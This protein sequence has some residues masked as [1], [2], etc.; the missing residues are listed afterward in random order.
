VAFDDRQER[1]TSTMTHFQSL[2]PR[3]K[4]SKLSY[5]YI[6]LIGCVILLSYGLFF[7]IQY[8]IEDDT[9]S[10]LVDEQIHNQVE[11]TK[12]ISQHISSDL[13]AIVL[14]LYGLA[15]SANLQQGDLS[16]DNVQN[17]MQE[18]YSQLNA[19][20]VVDRLIILDKNNIATMFI[21]PKEQNDPY[22]G[23]GD[24]SFEQLVNQTR[25]TLRPEFMKGFRDMDGTYRVAVTYPII[26]RQTNEYVG[27]ISALI[28]TIKFFEHYGNVHDIKTQ[29]LV[30]FDRDAT[31]LTHPIKQNIGKNF[32]DEDF[33]KLIKHNEDYNNQVRRVIFLSSTSSSS[34]DGKQDE[35]APRYA[36][37]DYGIGERLSTG[38]SILAQAKPAYFIFLVT[39]TSDIYSEAN[40][41]LLL[42][43]IGMFSLLAGTTTAIALLMVFLLKWNRNLNSEVKRRTSEL[44][45]SNKELELAND[46]LNL[47]DK[48]QKDFVNIA[49]HELRTPLQ[50]IM[51]YSDLALKGKIDKGEALRTIDRQANKLQKLAT[52]LL[53]VSRIEG[54]KLSYMIEKVKINDLIIEILRYTAIS[55]GAV[56]TVNMVYR[57][58]T[59]END[60][61]R[62]NNNNSLKSNKNSVYQIEKDGDFD[63]YNGA[64]DYPNK[65]VVGVA[66]ESKSAQ[67]ADKEKDEEDKEERREK[68]EKHQPLTIDADL[69]NNI[70]E[71]DADKDRISQVLSNVIDNAVKF[72][73]KGS[74]K[75]ETRLLISA[76]LNNSDNGPHIENN[77][78]NNKIQ[79]RVSDSGTGIPD[80]LFPRLFDK[81]AT[82]AISLAKE[83]RQGTGLGLFIAKSI[84]RAHNGKIEAYNNENGGAT[85]S[86][87]LPVNNNSTQLLTA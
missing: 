18:V 34:V 47:Q 67:Q 45:E 52:D 33:Q 3:L 23:S 27:S 12:K 44:E 28:P 82:R 61:N 46:Q 32:F 19:F 87:L 78:N 69:D 51:S 11:S 25:K 20:T 57:S 41:V 85:F 22:F 36:M 13:D 49:A 77:N 21:V 9:K 68:K 2:I 60:S 42:E 74:V 24:I 14:A 17:L 31:F 4:K 1:D 62:S 7:Y 65:S 83:S 38:L 72:T 55:V 54:G 59:K 48:M 76:G 56:L 71:I 16:S 10:R 79:I 81:F 58:A 70:K 40:K 8:S 39:P 50:P 53:A 26:N 75:I 80:E 35:M 84:I 30:A 73:R 43:R 64:D 37:Y 15:N 29:Y 66:E 86:I 5:Y 63:D 6:I